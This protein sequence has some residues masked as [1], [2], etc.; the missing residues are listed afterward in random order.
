MIEVK[1]VAMKHGE[2]PVLKVFE[3]LVLYVAE[4]YTF[5]GPF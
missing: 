1:Q 3:L 2:N 5:I 4:K